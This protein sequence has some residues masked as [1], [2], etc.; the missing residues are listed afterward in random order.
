LMRILL[1][2]ESE[3]LARQ[4]DEQLRRAHPSWEVEVAKEANAH[5][6]AAP[7]AAFDVV[8]G[9]YREAAE[10][11]IEMLKQLRKAY[12]DSVVVAIGE[13]DKE[14]AWP[15][16]QTAGVDHYLPLY[17]K[18]T[19]ALDVV[20]AAAEGVARQRSDGQQADDVEIRRARAVLGTCGEAV[21]FTNPSGVVVWANAQALQLLG[22]DGGELVGHPFGHLLAAP[23]AFNQVVDVLSSAGDVSSVV[24]PQGGVVAVSQPAADR[25]ELTC[26][27]AHKARHYLLCKLAVTAVKDASGSVE[28]LLIVLQP[29]LP[30]E[31]S[32][33]PEGERLLEKVFEVVSVGLGLVDKRGNILR[34]N[35]ELAR[36]TGWEAE[37]L[38][39]RP[40]GELMASA[41]P[42]E[43]MLEAAG[44]SEALQY[45]ETEIVACDGRRFTAGVA[46]ARVGDSLDAPL[47]VSV[48]DLS[49]IRSV[50]ER[51]E[52][53]SVGLDN[54]A[55][56]AAGVAQAEKLQDLGEAAVSGLQK[57]VSCD[58]VALVICSDDLGGECCKA[59]AGLDEETQA[60]L[61]GAVEEECKSGQAVGDGDV[62]L[63]G[64]LGEYWAR[65][66]GPA[67]L[68]VLLDMGMRSGGRVPLVIGGRVVGLLYFGR[69]TQ[70][71]FAADLDK[72]LSAF[73][74]QAAGMA[75]KVLACEQMQHIADRVQKILAVSLGVNLC[76]DMQTMTRQIAEAAA[77]IGEAACAWAGV[78]GHQRR[79]FTATHMYCAQG[80]SGRGM[81]MQVHD[82]AWSAIH[83]GQIVSADVSTRGGELPSS[84][85][86]P[87]HA[88]AVPMAVNGEAC[89]AV[90]VVYDDGSA[91]S[92]ERKE[93]VETLAKHAAVAVRHVQLLEQ[94][95]QRN[96][97]LET[98]VAEAWEAEADARTLFETAAVIVETSELDSILRQI[99]QA[100]AT[101]IRLE[102]VS[103]YLADHTRQVLAG[104]VE[105]HR[106]GEIRD[107]SGVQVEL[108]AGRNVL[109][110]AALGNAPYV[111]IPTAN[112]DQGEQYE[113][114]LVPLRSQDSLVGLIVAD[115]YRS[116]DMISA[117]QIRLLRSL[118]TM[119]SVAIERVRSDALRTHFLS[120]VSH[121]LRA[122]LSSIRAYNELVLDGEAGPINEEQREYLSRVETAC[123]WLK[124]MIED[125]LS[126]SRLKS[127]EVAIEKAPTDVGE[128]VTGVVD[129][130]YPQ[131]E[132]SEV[133][134]DLDLAQDLPIIY[135]DPRRVEQIVTN[136]IDNAIKFNRPGGKVKV[137]ARVYKGK[138]AIAVADT[139]MGI[140]A[141]MQD[142]VFGEFHRGSEEVSR[143]RQGVGLGLAIASQLAGYL[144]GKIT[145]E[146]EPGR[147]SVFLLWLPLEIVSDQQ[148][149]AGE[150]VWQ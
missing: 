16:V 128:V 40:F 67:A 14:S 58:A 50:Q 84:Q 109:A 110:D 64:D 53:Y 70:E 115:N 17:P 98:L 80:D 104:A 140:P 137:S 112:D 42:W 74:A 46:V 126:W 118:A 120:T 22:Y 144:G 105:A 147:G 131:A 65:N 96:A 31:V 83:S 49:E 35:A 32:L 143:G 25:V 132:K 71:A 12:P 72:A 94:A 103:I 29:V 30:S 56:A 97:R 66:R 138:M 102:R 47:L 48:T 11:S 54:L 95:R 5:L 91:V 90:V 81:H 108:Q 148:P 121:E 123:L 69:R 73:I 57:V 62:R 87:A 18:W 33:L 79:E 122:P 44:N 99:A 55:A 124:R 150:I 13:A 78:L 149:E 27:L 130:F 75:G 146:S 89:G 24:H 15:R 28:S 139:G 63:I 21:L 51:V 111:V 41:Q 19:E 129:A 107:I 92:A 85:Q 61:L 3:E 106:D 88:V 100:A 134:L 20:A 9:E 141:E 125:L 116:Q 117:Q 23:E 82:M 127:G 113:R 52:Q 68:K 119:A 6:L 142:K 133:R 43:Q 59:A 1:V 86:P 10:E 60:I 101:K 2:T 38:I 45:R 8:V 26:F 136:L 36:L 7:R 37:Q 4:A 114:L 39:G 145:V 93:A 34:A 76:T 135:T 77:A